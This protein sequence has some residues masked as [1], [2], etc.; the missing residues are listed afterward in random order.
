MYLCTLPMFAWL[1]RP[2]LLGVHILQER[3]RN[4]PCSVVVVAAAV[5]FVIPGVIALRAMV[6]GF[7]PYRR[8][9]SVHVCRA[10]N[11]SS[12]VSKIALFCVSFVGRRAVPWATT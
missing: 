12:M 6:S 4:L 10:V 8:S 5:F 1:W 11:L 3:K 7:D 9:F 2:G